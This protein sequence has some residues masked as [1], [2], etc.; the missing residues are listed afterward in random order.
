MAIREAEYKDI[1]IM[2]SLLEEAHR[3]GTY[4]EYALEKG[5]INQ[6]L[7]GVLQRTSVNGDGGTCAFVWE[8]DG[9]QGLL[10]GVRERIYHV[11]K[12]FRATDIFFYIAKEYNDS[13]AF[14]LLLRA[15]EE[16]AWKHPRVKRID[17]GITDIISDPKRLALIYKRFGYN[18]YG[19]M[20]G[21]H[22]AEPF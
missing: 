16:W 19:V 2:V 11:S 13:L 8:D 21:K 15:F 7:S 20:V 18:E 5:A 9:V 3:V 6:L 4:R 1:P 22:R 17:L 12:D 14:R 10:L